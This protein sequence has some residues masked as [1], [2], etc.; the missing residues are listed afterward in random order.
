ML[1]I[2]GHSHFGSDYFHG[3]TSIKEYQKLMDDNKINYGFVM[4]TPGPVNQEGKRYLAWDIRFN[5]IYYYSE[6]LSVLENPYREINANYFNEIKKMDDTRLVYVPLVHPILDTREYLDELVSMT[7]PVAL[8]IHGVGA[9]VDPFCIPRD[10]T[11]FV[12]EKDLML[13]VHTDYDAGKD[14]VRYDTLLLRNL[15]TPFR[16]AKYLVNNRIYGVLN[17]GAALDI[18]TL[19]LVNDEEYL[20]IGLGPDLVI[21]HDKNRVAM[22]RYQLENIGYL[23]LLKKTVMSNNIIFDIDFDWNIIPDKIGTKLDGDF[24]S[25]VKENWNTN[26]QELIFGKNLISH[27]KKFRDNYI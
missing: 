22:D 1:I 26:E 5:K 3:T 27:C 25:R 9:G 6:C 16:W 14:S 10:F 23:Q 2:D 13:I 12:R 8:K 17:H 11:E 21:Q 20:K 4:P 15:N 24:V 18:E 7:N 19:K